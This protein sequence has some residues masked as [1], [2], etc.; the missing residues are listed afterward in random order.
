MEKEPKKKK[1]TKKKKTKRP[2]EE[3]EAAAAG[4]SQEKKS[5]KKKKK[6][7]SESAE[8]A[9]QAA[10][11]P[12]GRPY[13]V[14]IALPGSIV[15]NAQS[16]ELRTYLAGIIARAVT[17]FNV[18]EVVVFREQDPKSAGTGEKTMNGEFKGASRGSDPNIFLARVLQYLETPQYLRKALFPVH[19]D[20]KYA[21][22]LNP[23]DAPHHV[24]FETNSRYREGVVVQRPVRAGKGSLVNVGLRKEAQI[25]RSLQPGTRVTVRVD[26]FLKSATAKAV[27]GVAVAPSEP[28]ET[29]GMYWGYNTR[30]AAG[31]KEVWTEAPFEG[32]Y[33]LSVGTSENGTNIHAADT[34]LPPFKHL[35]IVFGGLAGLESAV[36]SDEGVEATGAEDL[37]DLYINA[38]PNQGSGTIRTEEAI[39]IVMSAMLR[40]YP[41]Y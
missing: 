35:L 17:V 4:D 20:L 5:K 30:V 31:L 13:T 8:S 41:Q 33:D 23:L 6:S 28:R 9:P 14:S 19:T 24:R 3:V 36:M 11:R 22:L 29:H 32:G 34:K 18:D 38:V 7:K 2:V 12:R 26:H 15:A 37:F 21:G 25:D 1:S 10:P 40:H 27:T 16:P 39:P